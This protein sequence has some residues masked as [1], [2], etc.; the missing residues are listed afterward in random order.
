VDFNPVSYTA[1]VQLS[2]YEAVVHAPVLGMYGPQGSHDLVSLNSLLGATVAMILIGGQYHVLSTMPEVSALPVD[3]PQPEASAS[4]ETEIELKTIREEA[5]TKS[6]NPNR[7]T[8]LL[9]GDK[10]I[11][12][13]EG[14]EMGVFQGGIAKLKASPMAQFI[15]GKYKDLARLIARRVQVF[16]D[17][18]EVEIFHREGGKVGLEIRG[19]ADLADETHP[20]K[21]IWTALVTIGHHEEDESRR[22]FI[23][24]R[25]GSGGSMATF[26]M[27]NAGK[28]EVWCADTVNVTADSQ[29]NI[30]G[31]SKVNIKGGAVNIN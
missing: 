23:E 28:V 22:L 26:S 1:S 15:L 8:D 13:S 20:S 10:L 12:A 30:T 6:F 9:P 19:G 2:S 4:S 3:G 25:D 7:S 31:N 29:V 16:S 11:R 14:A 27:S 24:T 17:F 5:A 21:E 18:G